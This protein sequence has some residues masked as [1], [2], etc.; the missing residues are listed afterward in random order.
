M[1]LLFVF[2]DSS[3]QLSL[4]YYTR[5]YR[6]KCYV[7]LLLITNGEKLIR[8]MV[9]QGFCRKEIQK[10]YLLFSLIVLKVDA[11]RQENKNERIGIDLIFD[12]I[13]SFL[14]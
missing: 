13:G 5:R 6:S 14:G 2:V 1:F 10:Y 8:K 11:E 4:E 9:F 12:I 7:M 3:K